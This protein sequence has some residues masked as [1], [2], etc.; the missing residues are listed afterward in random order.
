MDEMRDG[1]MNECMYALTDGWV[2]AWRMDGSSILVTFTLPL[3]L[4][5]TNSSG[6]EHRP[7]CMTLEQPNGAPPPHTPRPAVR[8]AGLCM[9]PTGQSAGQWAQTLRPTF[10]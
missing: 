9:Q 10:R 7:I 1:W 4:A 6:N 2:D 5:P 8:Y 3:L